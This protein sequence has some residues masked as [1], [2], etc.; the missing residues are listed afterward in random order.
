MGEARTDIGDP[1]EEARGEALRRI[2]RG[3]P[4]DVWEAAT[5]AVMGAKEIGGLF[6]DNYIL[7]VARAIMA[8]RERCAA[9]V[10]RLPSVAGNDTEGWALRR[11][12][13]AIRRPA[14]VR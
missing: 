12:A 8:E 2:R 9:L 5:A 13:Q 6:S 7:P 14:T 4:D 11:A 3:L 10:E 1:F